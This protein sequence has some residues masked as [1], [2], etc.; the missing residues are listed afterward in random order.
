MEAPVHVLI[1]YD[2]RDKSYSI[3]NCDEDSLLWARNTVLAQQML[4]K[5]GYT[6]SQAR[7]GVIR[8]VMNNG[9]AIRMCDVAKMASLIDETGKV[10]PMERI[11]TQLY[12][13]ADN[14]TISTKELTPEGIDKI[15]RLLDELRACI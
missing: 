5:M 3:E 14:V 12:E 13:I 9:N 10:Y 6:A 2:S 7:E 11:A 4:R 15:S 8:A 1:T